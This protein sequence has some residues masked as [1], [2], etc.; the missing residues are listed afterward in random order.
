MYKKA[1]AL[2]LSAQMVIILLFTLV[3]HWFLAHMTARLSCLQVQMVYKL[4]NT[5]PAA[6]P[7]VLAV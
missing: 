3:V 4:R 5:K 6:A 1:L 7:L 2:L